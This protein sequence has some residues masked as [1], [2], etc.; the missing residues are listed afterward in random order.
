MKDKKLS[1]GITVKSGA[2]TTMVKSGTGKISLLSSAN[3]TCCQDEKKIE[4]RIILLW[5]PNTM[6]CAVKPR[7][8]K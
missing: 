3:L 1:L 4:H 5:G 7:N 2:R 8:F 6:L